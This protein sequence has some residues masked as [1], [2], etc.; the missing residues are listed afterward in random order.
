MGRQSLGLSLVSPPVWRSRI[1]QFRTSSISTDEAL[2]ASLKT[3]FAHS[4]TTASS[5]AVSQRNSS[6]LLLSG[7]PAFRAMLDETCPCWD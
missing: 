7:P 5:S 1:E 2:C 4:R 3:R 6:L